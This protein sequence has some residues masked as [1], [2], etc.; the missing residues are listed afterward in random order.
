MGLKVAV[1]AFKWGIEHSLMM[2][3]LTATPIFWKLAS[4]S[5]RDCKSI[6]RLMQPMKTNCVACPG[7]VMLQMIKLI[8]CLW[9]LKNITFKALHPHSPLF[10]KDAVKRSESQSFWKVFCHT[11]WLYQLFHLQLFENGEIQKINIHT[12]T[13]VCVW[14]FTP[15]WP[16]SRFLLPFLSPLS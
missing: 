2:T 9:R 16:G 5:A 6:I 14:E 1:N 15:G 11:L 3:Q 7:Q 13:V 4:F 8:S 10:A 12:Y